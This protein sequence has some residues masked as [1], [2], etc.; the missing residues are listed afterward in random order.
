STSPSRPTTSTP[1]STTRSTLR[2]ATRSPSRATCTTGTRSTSEGA[3]E[4]SAV[5]DRE[6]D[7]LAP[8]VPRPVVVAEVG[9]PDAIEG[10][11]D[12]GRRDAAVAVSD[13]PLVAAD[14]RVGDPRA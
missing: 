7:P 8:L 6:V 12:G 11:Q 13:H 5:F 9:V 1:T 4:R 10:E 14:A 2:G 3:R